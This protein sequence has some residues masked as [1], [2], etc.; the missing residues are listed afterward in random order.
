MSVD[1]LVLT[2]ALVGTG[3]SVLSTVQGGVSSVSVDVSTQLRGQ[4]IE[5]S[6]SSER[7]PGGLDRVQRE[8]AARAVAAEREEI[9]VEPWLSGYTTARTDDIIVEELE[10]LR[11]AVGDEEG[12]V[13]EEET[14]LA[15]L[16][17]FAVTEGLD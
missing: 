8:E 15:A 13:S 14:Y 7:C 6:F 4:V 16:E 9:L 2:A 5:R 10:R 11:A 12:G 3:I 1:W 17:C